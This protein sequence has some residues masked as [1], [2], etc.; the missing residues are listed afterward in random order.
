MT[1]RDLLLEQVACGDVAPPLD[2]T[3]AEQQRIEELREENSRVL[4]RQPADRALS[5]IRARARRP[6][7]RRLA[8]LVPA[9]AVAMLL[10]VALVRRGDDIVNKGGRPQLLIYEQLP[11]GARLLRSGDGVRPGTKIQLAYVANGN[12]FGV[13]VSLDDAGTVSMH[14]PAAA[15]HTPRL[16]PRG[17]T[18]L[19]HAFELDAT[20][21]VERF[22][23]VTSDAPLEAATVMSAAE[24]LARAASQE[25]LPL[26]ASLKQTVVLLRKDVEQSP[27]ALDSD[28]GLGAWG[29][30]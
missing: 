28:G 4:Q 27:G 1:R 21:G 11:Q 7:A 25:L 18:R 9:V 5:A 17:E 22:F 16:E 12:P 14:W 19:P 13:I 2:L 30:P 20:P 24:A 29:E 10:V 23:L 26:P 15:T 8:V 3:P 6:L